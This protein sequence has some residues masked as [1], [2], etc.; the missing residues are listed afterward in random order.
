[1]KRIGLI[2]AAVFILAGASCGKTPYV[3]NADNP[4]TV[5]EENPDDNPFK[6]MELDTRSEA[7]VELGKTFAFDFI[8]RVND[9][10]EESFIV[11]PLSMQF[12][13]G[14]IL[15]GAQ[16]ETADEI[17]RV[18]G[19]EAGDIQA[20]NEFASTMLEQ[21]PAMDKTTAL[22]IGNAVFVNQSYSILDSYRSCVVQYYDAEVSN[23]DFA[24]SERA[25]GKINQWCYDR[26]NGL[27]DH[28]LDQVDPAILAFLMNAVYFKGQWKNKFPAETTAQERFVDE[29]G[30]ESTVPM[31]KNDAS[32]L[33]QENDGFRAIRLPYGN[34]AYQMTVILPKTGKTLKDAVSVLDARQWND[35]NKSLSGC[36]VDVWLPKFETKSHLN[37][38]QLLIEMGMP[39]AFDEMRAD[40]SAMSSVYPLFFSLVMQDA[41]I[42]VDEEGTEAAAVSTG[43]A[44]TSVPERHTFH[45]DHPFL[46][47]ITESST[48]AILFAGK[49]TK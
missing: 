33:Y 27:I 32:F 26:T 24:D 31:M 3:E 8:R 49:F 40:F 45:A 48:G 2:T 36:Q 43:T 13:L 25:A 5:V 12:L 47:L 4:D 44:A 15:D 39:S 11:S 21:L 41:V 42:K 10:Q 6:K 34:G 1:M 18:L 46:Y 7:I 16:G 9:V 23:L 38:N 19:Y 28:V 30:H 17:C 20:A 37:L 22:S 14:M 35:L 29:N